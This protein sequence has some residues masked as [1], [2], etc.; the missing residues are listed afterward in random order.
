VQRLIELLPLGPGN[1]L[2]QASLDVGNGALNALRH[3]IWPPQIAH[4]AESSSALSRQAAA[5]L[6]AR[7]SSVQPPLLHRPFSSP[8]GAP[9]E[10]PPCILQTRFPFT[11]GDRHDCPDRVFALQR[12]AWAKDFGSVLKL[13]GMMVSNRPGG[14][15]KWKRTTPCIDVLVLVGVDVLLVLDGNVLAG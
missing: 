6:N 8:I 11:A 4:S 1:A 7:A 12:L 5:F 2:R 13:S 14:G 3:L 10:A 15:R 9:G